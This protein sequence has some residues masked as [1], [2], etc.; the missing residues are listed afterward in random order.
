[1]KRTGL[2]STLQKTGTACIIRSPSDPTNHAYLED[3]YGVLHTTFEPFFCHLYENSGSIYAVDRETYLSILQ[4]DFSRHD[5]GEAHS[6]RGNYLLRRPS[7]N[8]CLLR[9]YKP[10]HPLSSWWLWACVLR[11]CAHEA[12]PRLDLDVGAARKVMESMLSSIVNNILSQVSARPCCCS[13]LWQIW[14]EVQMPVMTT[15]HPEFGT[16]SE[17]EARFRSKLIN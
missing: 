7:G 16:T 14:G 8:D 17:R 12:A 5:V 15:Q 2:L 13:R 10:P 4:L 9:G 11:N 3:Y 1:M 6:S